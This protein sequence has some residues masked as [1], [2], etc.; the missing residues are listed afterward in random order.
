MF[1]GENRYLK[2]RAVR[3]GFIQSERRGK[4]LQAE[5]RAQAKAQKLD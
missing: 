1:L 5:G 2:C 3:K 4:L